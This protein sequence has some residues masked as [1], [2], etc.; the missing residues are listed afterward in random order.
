M[1]DSRQIHL[2]IIPDGNRRWARQHTLKPWKGHEVGMQQA[3]KLIDWAFGDP[4]VLMLTLWGLSTENWNRNREELKQ[5]MRIYEELLQGER[6]KF[7]KNQ[8]RFTHSGRL[9]RIPATLAELILAIEAETKYYKTFTLNFAIDYGGK[10][11]IMRAIRNITNFKSVSEESFR[12]LLD[13]PDLPDIDL[14][15]RTSGE[16]RLS[17][18]FFW[19]AAYAELWFTPKYFPDLEPNDLNLAVTDYY[20][21]Q[22][23]FGV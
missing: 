18:F 14:I 9:D 15:V 4:R 3:K 21:R 10:D 22:R 2:A 20:S 8:T 6:K 19:Q 7:V 11:D 23:R 1:S 17:N 16:Q 12:S 13:I 5:L